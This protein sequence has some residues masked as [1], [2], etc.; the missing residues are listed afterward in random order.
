MFQILLITCLDINKS[1]RQRFRQTRFKNLE[2]ITN[3]LFS[4]NHFLY[5]ITIGD[6]QNKLLYTT[7][8]YHLFLLFTNN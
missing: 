1:Y 3:T 2:K 6:I 5:L 7:N 4:R 8:S